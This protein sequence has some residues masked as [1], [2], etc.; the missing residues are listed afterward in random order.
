MKSRRGLEGDMIRTV[1]LWI[2]F[3]IIAGGAIFMLYRLFTS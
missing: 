2:L 3:L 1:A